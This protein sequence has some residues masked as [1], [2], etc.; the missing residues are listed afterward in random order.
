LRRILDHRGCSYFGKL[1]QAEL[2]EVYSSCDVA[3]VPYRDTPFNR[4]SFP[5]KT[6]EYLAA[7]LPVVATPLPSTLWLGSADVHIAERVEDFVRLAL[8]CST[9]RRDEDIAR[10][11]SFA[12]AHSWDARARDWLRVLGIP[13]RHSEGTSS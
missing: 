1:P 2:P 3:L 7:G 11:R 12:A 6:L 10:R 5:L 4:S 13:I 9:T 8:A